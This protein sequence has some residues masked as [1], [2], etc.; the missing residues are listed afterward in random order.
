MANN[1]C[2]H[3]FICFILTISKMRIARR[4]RRRRRRQRWRQCHLHRL[5]QTNWKNSQRHQ[6]NI[7]VCETQS[8]CVA[9][10]KLINLIEIII[11]RACVY[12]CTRIM[13]FIP[14][15]IRRGRRRNKMEETWA[16]RQANFFA[17]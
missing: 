14:S 4:R 7:T 1:A 6:Q 9:S 2:L 8:V 17:V 15:K 11:G 16:G 13:I 5:Q 10:I 3:L 12:V